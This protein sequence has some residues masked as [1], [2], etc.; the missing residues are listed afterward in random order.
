[1]NNLQFT[2]LSTVIEN[3]KQIAPNEINFNEDLI[4][5]WVIDAYYDIGTYKQFKEKI[6]TLDIKNFKVKLPC[7]F[8]ESIFVLV[9]PN[10]QNIDNFFLTELVKQDF[11]DPN[12]TWTY[13]KNCKCNDNCICDDSYLETNGWLYIE[14]LEKAKSLNF[15]TVTDFTPWFTQNKK[16][17]VILQP[18]TSDFSLARHV[19][20][21]FEKDFSP[22]NVYTI[23]NG[24]L[25]TNFKEAKVL[26]G[27]LSTPLDNENLPLIPNTKNYIS[28]LI[29]SIE[30]KL[31]YIQYRKSKSNQ[32]LNFFQVTQ[33]EYIKYKI[34]AREDLNSQTFDEM[35]AMGEATNQFLV[36]N[37]YHGLNKRKPQKINNYF[38]RY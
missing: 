19:S 29:A 22:Q 25:I 5:E 38:T 37:S 30:E 4:T 27:F 1:M 33:K 17:W 7:G 34:K 8:K 11:N 13:R 3:W 20:K 16:D 10:Y 9:K 6:Q 31:A 2:S 35:W 23:D 24:Y 12:C 36:P 26:I 15:A 32:D 18:K 21:E 14:N 28:A